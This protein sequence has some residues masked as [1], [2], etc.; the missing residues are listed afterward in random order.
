ML[1]SK[2]EMAGDMALAK[3]AKRRKLDVEVE[4]SG[5][6]RSQ[7]E[8]SGVIAD[9]LIWA[10]HLCSSNTGSLMT[11]QEQSHALSL[12]DQIHPSS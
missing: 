1:S 10:L 11:P 2:P 6:Q 9:H 3:D 5:Q 12:D 7:V 8:P 4:Q